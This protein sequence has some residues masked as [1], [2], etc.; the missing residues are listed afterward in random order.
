VH[1]LDDALV[2]RAA[3][4]ARDATLADDAE[5]DAYRARFGEPAA[6]GE[7]S[8]GVGATVTGDEFWL[9]ATTAAQVEWLCEAYDAGPYCTT[10][11]EDYATATALERFG[12]LERYLSVRA[13]ANFDRPAPGQSV[14]AHL[15]DDDEGFALDLALENARRVGRA[16]VEAVGAD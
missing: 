1:R 6:R 2:E 9:G 12:H 5:L 7:P 16:V 11:M 8:V 4:A 3:A 13:V 14:R 15:A 10:Q